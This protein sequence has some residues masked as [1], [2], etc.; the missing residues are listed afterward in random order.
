MNLRGV[1]KKV[2]SIGPF[3]LHDFAPSSE[4]FRDEVLRGLARPSKSI[5]SK[6]FYDT[7]GSRLFDDICELE[8][9]YPTRTEVR[10]LAES[11]KE[12]R[13]CIGPR[14]V[15]VELG[16]GSSIKTRMLLDHLEEPIYIPVDIAR[17]H[18]IA[19]TALLC[20]AYPDL[21]IIPV[22]A[23]YTRD[24]VL[25]KPA[26]DAKWLSFFFPGSTI[27]NLSRDEAVRFLVH[28]RRVACGPCGVLV[29]VDLKKD[30]RVLEAAYN[31]MKG[32]TAAFN[33]NLLARINRELE[34]DF[35]LSSFRHRAFYNEA[36]SRVEM[37][38]VSTVEQTAHVGGVAV[39]FAEGESIL[40]EYSH[41]YSLESMREIAGEGGFSVDK[42][43]TDPDGLFSVQLLNSR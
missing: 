24:F 4:S 13:A 22:C 42:V 29:G 40:T 16:A 10:I 32:V 30:R 9:Y 6:F 18:L 31:D 25:P 17:E 12:M 1:M 39:R 19:S 37:H 3:T 7:T 26:R 14:A 35:V 5:P 43:W 33:L 34:G 36:E 21:E 38:L 8:E 27:G 28:L 11:G 20:D 23:D 15:L 41:K 2:K